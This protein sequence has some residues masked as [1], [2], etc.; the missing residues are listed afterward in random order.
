MFAPDVAADDRGALGV[1]RGGGT[2]AVRVL[3]R[4]E[5][6]DDVVLG[7]GFSGWWPLSGVGSILGGTSSGDDAVCDMFDM[8]CT[9]Q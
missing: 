4:G 8:G 5:T 9:R 6:G 7:T 2:T 3:L 1:M